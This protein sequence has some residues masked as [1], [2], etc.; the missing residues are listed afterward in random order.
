MVQW[1]VGCVVTCIS[2]G[3]TTCAGDAD[4]P[5]LGSSGTNILVTRFFQT[6]ETGISLTRAIKTTKKSICQSELDDTTWLAIDGVIR[7]GIM[8]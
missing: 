4:T 6:P 3:G 2:M 7:Y 8:F 5:K 1:I